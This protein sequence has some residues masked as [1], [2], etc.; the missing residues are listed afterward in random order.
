MFVNNLSCLTFILLRLGGVYTIDACMIIREKPVWL[1]YIE[2]A[3]H[4]LD[5]NSPFYYILRSDYHLGD[6]KRYYLELP[7]SQILIKIFSFV[8]NLSGDDYIKKKKEV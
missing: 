8:T 1:R 7:R 5:D 4:N 2:D 6:Q 3:V